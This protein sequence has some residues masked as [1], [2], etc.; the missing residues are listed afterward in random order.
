MTVRAEESGARRVPLWPGEREALDRPIT[1][2]VCGGGLAGLAAATVLAE[3]G[4]FVTVLEAEES[5]GGRLRTWHEVLPDG[6]SVGMERGFHAFFRH[7]YNL[8][9]LLRR[10]DPELRRLMRLSDYPVVG[11]GGMVQSFEDLPKR[12]PANF[13]GIVRRAET[14]RWRDLLR[15]N[16]AAALEMLRYD[17]GRTY[18]RFDHVTAKEYLD[19]LR[20][21]PA[22]R[23]MLFEVF[24]HS[25]FNPEE[26]MSAAEL[27]MMFH[28]YFLGNREGLVF[29]VLDDTF[30]RA[31]LHPLRAYLEQRGVNFRLGERA[32]RLTRDP[33]GRWHVASSADGKSAEA[34]FDAAVLALS[35]P[36]LKALIARSTG[37]GGREWRAAVAGLDVTNPFAVWRL[38]LDGPTAEGRRPFT[39]TAGFPLLD[40]ISLYHLFE[41]ESR[42]WA[43]RTGGAV[44]ELHAY[45][46]PEN[47]TERELREAMSAGLR[48][49][50][51]ET[52]AAGVVHESFLLYRDCPAFPPGGNARRPGVWTSEPGLALA[53]D[54]VRLDFPSALM[55]RA[56]SSGFLAA[57]S[58]L[59]PYGVRPEPMR[60]IP[61]TGPL[62]RRSRQG[63][64]GERTYGRRGR[65]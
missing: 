36:G 19:S 18:R 29:D 17:P 52:A 48:E 6:T 58:L 38:W 26:E 4:A 50:L 35:V 41:R 10:V 64:P 31:L 54:F 14:F 3:R 20:F 55:E 28:Y 16:G 21:P 8:R 46:V 45:A 65:R 25:F 61:P 49:L 30:E 34:S 56:V 24:A 62:A 59:R 27:L 13:L 5:L 39:G 43:G 37:F 23:R 42:E 9:S 40:N 12:P 47:T 57:S 33:A 7:Y 60:S 51:P 63:R 11:P 2:V 15:T 1:A 22:A 53:G 44:V 32:E